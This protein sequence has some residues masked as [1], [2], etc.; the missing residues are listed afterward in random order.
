ML[1]GRRRHN[2][3]AAKLEAETQQQQ[4]QQTLSEYIYEGYCGCGRGEPPSLTSEVI[5]TNFCVTSEAFFILKRRR[6]GGERR[7]R[8]LRTCFTPSLVKYAA[9]GTQIL[10]AAK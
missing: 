7:R 8:T 2:F 4:Q 6:V 3:H 1:E 10:A 5:K 9:R